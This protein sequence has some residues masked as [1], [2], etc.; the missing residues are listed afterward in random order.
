MVN[1][2]GLPSFISGTGM[3]SSSIFGWVIG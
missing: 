2:T 3:P 1:G